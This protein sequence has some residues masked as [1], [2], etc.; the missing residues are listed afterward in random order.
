MVASQPDGKVILVGLNG[1][2]VEVVRLNP[3]GSVDAAFGG[4]G[5]VLAIPD[6]GFGGYVSATVLPDG[7]I[8]ATAGSHVTRDLA[9]AVLNPDGTADDFY[10][11][12]SGLGEIDFESGP[13]A[14]A[15]MGDVA[16]GPDGRIVLTVG[17][18]GFPL[19]S[20]RIGVAVLAERPDALPLRPPVGQPG[21]PPVI[22]PEP[23][24]VSPPIPWEP[25][26]LPIPVFTLPPPAP[27]DAT[28]DLNGDW[29]DDVITVDG[30]RLRVVSGADGTVLVDWFAPYEESFTGG[31]TALLL[32]MDGGD[33]GDGDARAEIVTAPR[34]GGSARIQVFGF[35]GG[36]LVQR[37]NFFAFPDDGNYRGGAS[38]AVGDVDDDG[39]AD[40]IVGAGNGG[41]PR[42]A[43]FDG[44]S[45]LANATNPARLVADFF[46]FDDPGF[47]GGVSVATH[48]MDSDGRADVLAG[49]GAGGAPRVAV[50]GG[51]D[52]CAGDEVVPLYDG[53]YGTDVSSRDGVDLAAEL[54]PGWYLMLVPGPT[55]EPMLY[56]IG[57][58][59][60][61]I[62]GYWIDGQPVGPV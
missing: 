40:L 15:A 37:D 31:I 26:P 50:F 1:E 41:G 57:M 42:V 54:T 4:S 22:P 52:L 9:V 14:G 39:R 36:R 27:P 11:D 56:K 35:A 16:V 13:M 48:N 51:A 8:V 62:R 28:G 12:G 38:I 43:V 47:R 53:F 61:V 49:A 55:D 10:A 19:G 45:L 17:F 59:M 2:G 32:Y 60:P 7:R 34:D 5:R 29:T 18:A 30:S 6:G 25:I 44:R 3:D 21:S 24:V 23:P 20:N 33:G 58:P 46:A